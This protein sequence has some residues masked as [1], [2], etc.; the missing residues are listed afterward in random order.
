MLDII[1]EEFHFSSLW[2]GGIFLLLSFAAII[3]LFL[4]PHDQ[5][6]TIWKSLLYLAGL[7]ILFIGIG[8]PINIIGR[9]EFSTHII[10]IILL[11]YVAPPLLLLGFKQK[12][13]E[14]LLSLSFFHHIV[15][16]LSHPILTIGLFY[17][18][19]Y[20][21]HLP[22]VFD[23]A[24]IELYANYFYM[25]GL[26][27]SAILLWIPLLSQNI[28]TVTQ[29]TLYSVLNIMLIVPFSL[30][31]WLINESL[32]TVYTD[33]TTFVASMELCLPPGETLSP[34]YF[35]M[36]LPFYP[37]GEQKQGGMM[38]LISQLIIFVSVIL[39]SRVKR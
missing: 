5:R 19:L 11:L 7:I 13:L 8:S 23:H 14:K 31:L 39:I 20:G 27:I 29:K 30:A 2:N 25:L 35:A 17:L 28:L 4:L 33:M 32:Y 12:P 15:K 3:Y 37:I 26:F 16:I 6:H 9:I 22:A 34:E 21:Y 36:L 18:L 24:R 1:L 10:Q 38:L